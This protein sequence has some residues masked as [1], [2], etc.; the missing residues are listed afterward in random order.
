[1]ITASY[2]QDRN[3]TSSTLHRFSTLMNNLWL[4]RANAIHLVSKR[5]LRRPIGRSLWKFRLIEVFSFPLIF[6]L[7]YSPSFVCV[8]AK[9]RKTQSQFDV[10]YERF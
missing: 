3:K 2:K 9:E 8:K 4:I 7:S 5:C 1:M 10:D 6:P